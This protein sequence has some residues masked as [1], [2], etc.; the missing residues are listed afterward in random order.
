[1]NGLNDLSGLRVFE[2]VVS[3][4][5]LTAAAHEL[6]ISLAA[7]SKRLANLEK[8]TGLQ[9]IHRSTRSLSV[10]S[11]GATLYQHAQRILQQ[12]SQAEEALLNQ[13]QQLS[14]S[15]R[16][17]S[18]NSFG[19]R[20]LLPLISEFTRQ[21][22]QIKLQLLLNDQVCDL[23]SDNI[24]VAIRYGE[25]PDSSLIAR[26][27]LPNN[28]IICAAP[29]YLQQYGQPDSLA[30]LA[31]HRCIVIGPH[32]EIEWRFNQTQV[33]INGHFLCNDGEAGHQ[34]ALRGVGI[35]M[36]SYLDVASD[37]QQ[38]RLVQ[39]LPDI[40]CANAPINLVYLRNQD[41][42]PRVKVLVDFLLQ[43]T[44]KMVS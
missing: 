13:Q 33:H 34:L 10:T 20:V 9:L 29:Q 24:D 19:Q 37:I 39:L 31:N 6:G 25:L 12:V 23:I 42:V 28:R 18:P 17:T 40:A 16:I 32:A 22:P 30:D 41:L 5:S 14:G 27:L 15:L 11:E 26:H 4:G 35:V 43:A 44:Q 2:R 1:M 21:Y 7:T 36:K 38:G 3:L 8:R